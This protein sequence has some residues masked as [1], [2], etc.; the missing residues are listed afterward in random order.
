MPLRLLVVLINYD[1]TKSVS[2]CKIDPFKVCFEWKIIKEVFCGESIGTHCFSLTSYF[3]E[4]ENGDPECLSSWLWVTP[5]G[6][7]MSL[8]TFF[9][10]DFKEKKA[11]QWHARI[12]IYSL[13]MLNR[14][15]RGNMWGTRFPWTDPCRGGVVFQLEAEAWCPNSSGL[16]LR[17]ASRSRDACLS[18]W[19]VYECSYV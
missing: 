5:L 17:S 2:S 15:K 10:G 13:L 4:G 18:W 11:I 1:L 8:Q 7:T 12:S 6:N 16:P 3:T 19:E 9:R 14:M